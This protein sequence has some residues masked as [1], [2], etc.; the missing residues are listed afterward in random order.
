MPVMVWFEEIVL[1]GW[2]ILCRVSK[3]MLNKFWRICGNRFFSIPFAKWKRHEI[4]N[5]AFIGSNPIWDVWDTYSHFF[6]SFLGYEKGVGFESHCVLGDVWCNGSIKRK[7]LVKIPTKLS[8]GSSSGSSPVSWAG[9]PGFESQSRY[10]SV[11]AVAK[12]IDCYLLT[13]RR[14]Q[15]AIVNRIVVRVIAYVKR[16]D[17]WLRMECGEDIP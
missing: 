17:T 10:Y 6:F 15:R 9:G 12:N 1:A 3:R 16:H 5:L 8:R 11:N 13:K 2:R 14:V 4:S 7:Y